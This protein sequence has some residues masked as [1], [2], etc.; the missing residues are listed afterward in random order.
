[1]FSKT[2][3]AGLA[4]LAL[5]NGSPKT[6]FL[7]MTSDIKGRLHAALLSGAQEVQAVTGQQEASLVIDLDHSD[8]QNGAYQAAGASIAQVKVGENPSTGYRWSIQDN[9]CGVRFVE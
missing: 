2:V 8:E 7:T 4:S 5:V 6:D 1:M 3:V 9:N